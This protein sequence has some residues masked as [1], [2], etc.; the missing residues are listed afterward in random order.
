MVVG[1]AALMLGVAMAPVASTVAVWNA[2]PPGLKVSPKLL[3]TLGE[4]G[5]ETARVIVKTASSDYASIRSFV[6]K[7]GGIVS[8][9]Y[10]YI[11]AVAL[12]LPAT[13]VFNLAALPSVLNV[14]LDEI[15]AG[16]E[17]LFGSSRAANLEEGDLDSLLYEMIE[18]GEPADVI[19]LTPEMME[20]IQPEAYINWQLLG[21]TPSVISETGGGSGTIIGYID[22]GFEP[23]FAIPASRVV[24]GVDVSPDVGTPFE[25]AIR[26]SNHGHGTFGAVLAAGGNFGLLFPATF[27]LIIS[28]ETYTGVSLPVVGPFKVLPF[29]GIA[30]D[31]Q[32]FIVKIFPHTGAGIPTS[33]VL[34][35]LEEIIKAK[36]EDEIDIDVINQS[37]G[38]GTGYDGRDLEDTLEAFIASLGIIIGTSAGNSGPN[39]MTTGSPGSAFDTVAV[40]AA[41]DAPHTRI[42]WDWNFATLGLG[43]SL[44][45]DDVTKV[46]Y[47]S[48]RGPTADGRPRPTVM[49]T[50]FFTFSSPGGFSLGW[51][52]GTSFSHPA[53]TGVISLLNSW[54]E[55]NGFEPTQM[56]IK[57]SLMDTAVLL[58]DFRPRDQ[59][60]GYVNAA[61]ALSH[62]QAGEFDMKPEH[63]DHSLVTPKELGAPAKVGAVVT[64]SINLNPGY[65]KEYIFWVDHSTEQVVVS[66][67]NVVVGANP[68]PI[69]QGFFPNSIEL[70]I[71]SGIRT[72]DPDLVDSLNIF[73]DFS[74]TFD[75]AVRTLNP[76]YWRVTV[77]GDWTNG[78]P[79]SADVSVE[80][81]Q[82]PGHSD[83]PFAVSRIG[84]GDTHF[85]GVD[86]PIGTAFATFE[87]SWN[88]DWSKYPSNDLDLILIS[89][90][91]MLFFGGATLNSPERET[92][93]EPEPGMWLVIVDGFEVYKSEKDVYKLFVDIS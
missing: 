88:F 90:S 86:V 83:T 54:A 3:A 61:S 38:G 49:A 81:I 50:G 22:T 59:G 56:Q 8:T 1:I 41:T 53:V 84:D 26:P 40:G 91:G 23:T 39:S 6:A 15:R 35:G 10:N 60:A 79:V 93:E 31:A 76:G 30:P 4:L 72:R 74:L 18:L 32:L 57:E 34:A 71:S 78:V 51:G 62:L 12:S 80:V 36:L 17:D 29:I 67:T 46:G 64:D 21:V 24:G 14:Y 65:S 77:E 13:K 42:F 69:A 28:Y 92:I 25:G 85:Y 82:G 70:Y 58:Q 45:V 7:A 73:S 20:D 11:N 87:L 55:M 63:K 16:P 75:R 43:A 9:E 19:E 27:S 68:D 44:Y 37:F 5:D 52:S 2:S 47:F 33:I 66:L 48:S 89:P